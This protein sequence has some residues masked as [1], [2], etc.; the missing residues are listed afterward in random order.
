MGLPEEGKIPRS[1]VIPPKDQIELGGARREERAYE[2]AANGRDCQGSINEFKVD[3][4]RA[5]VASYIQDTDER[6]S[7]ASKVYCLVVGWLTLIAVILIFQGFNFFGFYLNNDVLNWT[8]V[9]MGLNILGLLFLVI[10]YLF[11]RPDGGTIK[12]L[13]NAL[14]AQFPVSAPE[15]EKK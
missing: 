13:T 1:S 7:Y 12:D 3:Y 15:V 8:I 9:T 5:Q 4:A 10:R 11:H 14:N 2:R 6:K